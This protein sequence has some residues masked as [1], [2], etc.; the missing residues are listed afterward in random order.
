MFNHSG[1]SG[2]SGKKVKNN[3]DII[4]INVTNMNLQEQT[5]L[6]GIINNMPN[7]IFF[8]NEFY[9]YKNFGVYF[10]CPFV[11]R[12]CH[13]TGKQNDEH[14]YEVISRVSIGAGSYGDIYII[15]GTLVPPKSNHELFFFKKKPYDKQR[16][17]KMECNLNQSEIK[18]KRKIYREFLLT[19]PE[20]HMKMPVF[21]DNKSYLFMRRIQRETL[22]VFL[23]N[24]Y[25]PIN[26][27]FNLSLAILK[28]EKTQLYDRQI[29][30]RDLKPENI[31]IN[32]DSYTH[33]WKIVII[34]YG[35]AKF[36]DKNDI[37]SACGNIL[38]MSPEG[39][40]HE[41]TNLKSDVYSIGCIL[42]EVFGCSRDKFV[43]NIDAVKKEHRSQINLNNLFSNFKANQHYRGILKNFI[44]KTTHPNYHFR[45]SINE[46]LDKLQKIQIEYHQNNQPQQ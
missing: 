40:N 19:S 39:F 45:Y 16:V 44:L 38:Y 17:V 14:R 35:L 33:Q 22:L 23:K 3:I 42:S 30:H 41:G 15:E 5:I 31:M 32:Y 2:N 21:H 8:G 7:N 9:S 46:A 6:Q 25:L 37:G 27:I 20:L 28:A 1:N 10:I 26:E 34:D 12:A 18:F 24:F 11:K 36:S 4:D 13:P 43:K 29:V